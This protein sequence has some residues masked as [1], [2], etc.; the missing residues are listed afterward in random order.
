MKR[1]VESR[2]DIIPRLSLLE[3]DVRVSVDPAPYVLNLRSFSCACSRGNSHELLRGY[4][5]PVG[6]IS[7][8]V[9]QVYS[10]LTDEFQ[11][12]GCTFMVLLFDSNRGFLIVELAVAFTLVGYIY[13]VK[14]TQTDTA[15]VFRMGQN[16]FP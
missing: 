16:D 15:N 2:G 12:A 11:T 8:P 1:L 14:R 5:F 9:V 13:R 4:F 6:M 7:V 3:P 10:F